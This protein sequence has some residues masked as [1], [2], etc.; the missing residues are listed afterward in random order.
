MTPAP[1]RAARRRRSLPAADSPGGA[2]APPPDPALPWSR[3]TDSL[4]YNLPEGLIWLGDRRVLTLGADWFGDLRRELVQQ[5]GVDAARG[6][7]TRLGYGAGCRDAQM[8]LRLHGAGGIRDVIFAGVQFHA[9]QGSV[10]VVP[11]TYDVDV[12]AGRCH[13][14]FEWKNSVEV[15]VQTEQ[16]AAGALSAGDSACWMELGYSAGFLTTCMGQPIVVRE[17]SCRAAGALVCRCVAKPASEWA[18]T[19]D[20]AAATQ[21]VLP[22][23][24]LQDAGRVAGTV[25]GAAE[26]SP[27]SRHS[28]KAETA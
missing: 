14:E 13:L 1:P 19:A 21:P 15:Q 9:L 7:L 28:V 24:G 22:D 10:G 4:H 27:F 2:S 16:V 3:L 11:V 6:L 18:L 5:L 26:K 23:A 12:E 25:A 8:A 17:L 20:D